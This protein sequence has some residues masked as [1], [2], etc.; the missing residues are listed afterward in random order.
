VGARIL[1]VSQ[2]ASGSRCRYQ[3]SNCYRQFI[4]VGFSLSADETGGH[5]L[6]RTLGAESDNLKIFG[7]PNRTSGVFRADI[8]TA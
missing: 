4:H 5:M 6:T 2:L 7:F 1:V 8:L 3:E